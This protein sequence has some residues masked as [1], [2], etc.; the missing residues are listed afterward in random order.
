MLGLGLILLDDVD[1]DDSVELLVDGETVLEMRQPCQRQ[2]DLCGR[3]INGSTEAPGTRQSLADWKQRFTVTLANHTASSLVISIRDTFVAP[4]NTSFSAANNTNTTEPEPVTQPIPTLAPTDATAVLSTAAPTTSPT[5]SPTASPTTLADKA[6]RANRSFGVFSFTLDLLHPTIRDWSP[7]SLRLLPARLPGELAQDLCSAFPGGQLAPPIEAQLNAAA[8]ALRGDI[9]S[10]RCVQ[11]RTANPSLPLVACPGLMQ[12]Q[13]MPRPQQLHAETPAAVVCWRGGGGGGDVGGRNNSLSQPCNGTLTVLHGLVQQVDCVNDNA[14]ILASTDCLADATAGN[15][16]PEVDTRACAESS[17]SAPAP[18]TQS[19]PDMYTCC[20][21]AGLLDLAQGAEGWNVSCPSTC[22]SATH[23][24]DA[25]LYQTLSS[26]ATCLSCHPSCSACRTAGN[27]N[28]LPSQAALLSPEAWGP[29]GGDDAVWEWHDNSVSMPSPLGITAPLSLVS[30]VLDPGETVSLILRSNASLTA[31]LTSFAGLDMSLSLFT[32]LSRPDTR[33]FATLE[34]AGNSGLTTVGV[35]AINGSAWHVLH[36]SFSDFLSPTSTSIPSSPALLVLRFDMQAP[37]TP[38]TRLWVAAPMLGL[39][40]MAMQ[41]SAHPC[42]PLSSSSVS[43]STI[44]NSTYGCAACLPG[45]YL[46]NGMC[47]NNCSVL[48]PLQITNP[49]DGRCGLCS[50][51]CTACVG[52]ASTCM[53]CEVG[54]VLQDHACVIEC[55]EGYYAAP[56][57]R[58]G[59]T[60]LCTQCDSSCLACSGA[61]PNHCSAC[62]GP[63]FLDGELS[64]CVKTCPGGFYPNTTTRRC[65]AC[66][67]SCAACSS[68][69]GM[70]AC[71]DCRA[72]SVL[73]ALASPLPGAYCLAECLPQHFVAPGRRCQP[74]HPLCRA[75]NNSTAQGCTACGVSLVLGRNGSCQ[76]DCE[77]GEYSTTAAVAAVGESQPL[78]TGV[79][80]ACNSTCRS[81]DISADNCTSCFPAPAAAPFLSGGACLASCPVGTAA[82][83]AASGALSQCTPVRQASASSGAGMLAVAAAVP[84]VVIVLAATLL[85]VLVKRRKQERVTLSQA[86][87]GGAG[88]LEPKTSTTAMYSNPLFYG[89]RGA[90]AGNSGAGGAGAVLHYYAAPEPPSSAASSSGAQEYASIYAMPLKKKAAGMSDSYDTLDTSGVAEGVL[91]SAG[92]ARVGGQGGGGGAQD[93]RY[94][95]LMEAHT[96]LQLAGASS[97]GAG[98]EYAVAHSK[99]ASKGQHAQGETGSD[100]DSVHYHALE[101]RTRPN[102]YA[103]LD[104]PGLDGSSADDGDANYQHLQRE[105]LPTVWSS[106]GGGGDLL[107]GAVAVDGDRAGWEAA[108]GSAGM[109]GAEYAQPRRPTLRR[110]HAD[111]EQVTGITSMATGSQAPVYDDLDTS[112]VPRAKLQA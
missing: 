101:P 14:A 24:A 75:C 93:S 39:G 64:A 31:G 44:D 57:A 3:R 94:E 74:C 90:N 70:E 43:N 26:V 82:S 13:N 97:G 63:A 48:G 46:Q 67:V 5:P 47:I 7:S 112:N 99:S 106:D 37:D 32:R 40:S 109:T 34:V 100:V 4:I 1:G 6:L 89:A 15:V 104:R 98:S 12:P 61:G 80:R 27:C 81:C 35:K 59:D 29:G 91:A 86:G 38:D 60:P 30:A 79:C 56:P 105:R 33:A 2:L 58:P 51:H 45:S 102:A 85:V 108:P 41:F 103:S 16:P 107:P 96:N 8:F 23:E 36:W 20:S 87:A 21:S 65:D 110:E 9:P 22:P 25:A 54:F 10:G 17:L 66:D 111:H 76:A 50:D 68:G 78:V 83:A 42:A 49:L 92:G 69:A 73:Q 95:L 53:A 55:R 18:T 84:V 28:L 72:G 71:T 19:L 88:G 11:A 77:L 52:T 62:G